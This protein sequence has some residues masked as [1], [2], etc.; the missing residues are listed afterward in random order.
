[1]LFKRGQLSRMV[2]DIRR[3]AGAPLTNREIAARIVATMGW[4]ADDRA[5]L[6]STMYRV[7]DVTKRL[8]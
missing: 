7:K 5:V 1:M 4:D 2:L 3:E 6:V 8:A